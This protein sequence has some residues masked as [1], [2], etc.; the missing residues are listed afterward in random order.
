MND[1]LQEQKIQAADHPNNFKLP[2]PKAL[3]V[4]AIIV[5]CLQFLGAMVNLPAYFNE[6]Y[7]HFTLP[8][9]FLIG[10]LAALWVV[11]PYAKTNW[12]AIMEHVWMPTRI[13]LVVLSILMFLLLLPF[14]EFMTSMIPTSGCDWLENLYKEIIFAFEKM[15]DYKI[16]GFITVCILAP[17]FE[18]ILFRGIMLRGM[19]Q[20][21]TSPIWA[22]IISSFIF[23]LAHLN[24]WQ[25]LGAGL[26]G[27]VFGYVYYRTKS[28]WLVMFLHALNNTISYTMMLKFR[29]MEESV[30]NPNDY[31]SVVICFVI[32]ILIGWG[33][34][35]LTEKNLKW[36]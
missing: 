4:A 15:L 21:G 34:F 11:I 17:I 33:I 28:L 9:S 29:N 14:A 32:A 24:P 16:A 22:I 35:K 25:F 13:V 31:T 8:L 36:S 18:E 1:P 20:N 2:I 5:I 6:F 26:L 12:S 30:T 27:V 3:M 7:Y 23:G 10:S 19:L